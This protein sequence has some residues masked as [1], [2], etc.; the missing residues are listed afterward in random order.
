MATIEQSLKLHD[1]FSKVLSKIDQAT[2]NTLGTFEKLDNVMNKEVRMAGTDQIEKSLASIDE[3]SGKVIQG[4]EK[5][6]QTMDKMLENS[7]QKPLI[8]AEPTVRE[9]N[10]MEQ[11]TERTSGIF[12]RI[13]S[14]LD[15]LRGSA[16]T[17]PLVKPDATVDALET[18][19]KHSKN[20]QKTLG[21][22]H[23]DL[24]DSVGR[25]EQR[26]ELLREQ[27]RL[28]GREVRMLKGHLDSLNE[29]DAGQEAIL[30]QER[31]LNRANQAY[32]RN[33][34]AVNKSRSELSQLKTEL[35]H[36]SAAMS[37]TGQGGMNGFINAVQRSIT[38]T[39]TLIDKVKQVALVAPKEAVMSSFNNG[40]DRA[41]GKLSQM[42]RESRLGQSQFG[43]AIQ[44]TGGI[45]GQFF[46]GLRTGFSDLGR[47]TRNVM[48][49]TA[50][51][52]FAW[53][54]L[55]PIIGRVIQQKR[56]ARNEVEKNVGA[57]NRLANAVKYVKFG[58]WVMAL[59]KVYQML[60]NVASKIDE[61]T[62][63]QTRLNVMLDITGSETT[64]QELN[65]QI[66]ASSM[67]ARSAWQD[68]ANF[69]ARVGKTTN[70]FGDPSEIVAFS[71]LLQKSLRASGASADDMRSSM[72]QIALALQRGKIEGREL[73]TLMQ[74]APLVVKSIAD[75]FNMTTQELTDMAGEGLITADAIKNA[76]FAAADEIEER[77]AEVPITWADRWTQVR[78]VAAY[79]IEPLRQA[80]N[81]FINSETAEILFNSL[82]AGFVFVAQ[83]AQQAFQIIE[84]AAGWVA[85]NI[86][87]ITLGL[88]ILGSVAVAAAIA[89]AV[90]WAIANWP[91]V[92]IIMTVM[93]IITWLHNL[94]LTADMVVGF[95]AGA[96]MFLGTVIYNVISV[97]VGLFTAM[98]QFIYNQFVTFYNNALAV[99]EFFMNVWNNPV[100]STQKLFHNMVRS[101]LGFFA[102]MVDG[103]GSAG[104]AL[105]K[106]FISGVNMAVRAVNWLIKL[107]N[108]IPGINISTMGE[109]AQGGGGRGGAGQAIRN[110]ADRFDPGDAPDNYRSLD[111][112]RLDLKTVDTAGIFEGLQSPVENARKGYEWGSNLVSGV[113]DFMDNFGSTMGQNTDMLG[114]LTNKMGEAA[115]GLTPAGAGGAGR[116]GAADKLGKGKEVG[117]VGK[118]KSDVTI[119]EEDLKYLRDIAETNY[120]IRLQQISPHATVNYSS[121]GGDSEQDAKK[122]LD[123]MEDMIVEQ[124]ATNLL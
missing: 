112:M 35:D 19:Q 116:K 3:Q 39:Q 105:G 79:A 6:Q 61:M 63:I 36:V 94:G 97:A 34:E 120:I 89:F 59:R 58:V 5:M 64:L 48:T 29:S 93:L 110:M 96:I 103:A 2:Q 18:I 88:S 90:A 9:L 60:D 20:T 114:S 65:D 21:E 124:V 81:D 17:E 111:H 68:T 121:S 86:D 78:N 1:N 77:F 30:K 25:A 75:H 12:D 108:K 23:F 55:I 82:A 14:G 66:M 4:I 22:I 56:N 38:W 72:E 100:Y 13:R 84:I 118:I 99:A 44:K 107:I 115:K 109:F 15:N 50:K 87:L 16:V 51:L 101:I 42:F 32:L 49:T 7:N 8:E 27:M 41:R 31:A 33:I 10:T 57:T 28:Q 73:R 122:L 91:L 45:A 62:N 53:M 67:N 74:N 83:I 102:S 85:Q 43:Q 80:F 71:N 117:D 76:M 104:Q 106:A 54:K 70:I 95:M 37:Q 113:G 119:S 52:P 92:L 69:V 24:E 46:N 123:M 47:L 26:F 40:V 98:F 11:A